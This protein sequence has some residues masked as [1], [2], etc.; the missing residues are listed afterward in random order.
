MAKSKQLK[1]QLQERLAE[2]GAKVDEVSHELRSP[3]SA[4]WEERATESEGDEVLEALENSALAEIQQIQRTLGK[5]DDGS[6]GLCATC[7]GDIDEKRLEALP[8][9]TQCI[10]C[11]REA[12]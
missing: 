5:I 9:A 10:S 4:D 2:L 6:Y 7:G 12:G 1:A 11:A 8:Y 3:H